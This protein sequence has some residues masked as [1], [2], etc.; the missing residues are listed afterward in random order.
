MTNYS[1][2][3][4]DNQTHFNSFFTY[5]TYMPKHEIEIY[6]WKRTK[7]KNKKDNNIKFLCGKS[8]KR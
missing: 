7:E 1:K 5:P 6:K 4:K 3:S 2:F 8:F